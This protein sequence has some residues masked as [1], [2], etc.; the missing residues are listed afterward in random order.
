MSN[1]HAQSEP[2]WRRL[3]EERPQQIIEA[4]LEVFGEHGLSD[5]RLEDIAKRAGVS[6]GTIYLYFP[7]KEELFREV[8]RAHVVARIERAEHEVEA[9]PGSADEQLERFLRSWWTFLQLPT[10]GTIYRLVIGELHRFPDLAE[11]Y[12]KE[13]VQRALNL[14]AGFVRRGVDAGEFR[15]VDAFTT[16]RIMSSMFISHALWCS[17]REVFR[18]ITPGTA[19]QIIEDLID[20]VRSALRPI[21]GPKTRAR[22]VKHST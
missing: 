11:F 20:F 1:A 8:V 17:K 16:A 13:V 22:T 10:S 15:D 12:A 2:K 21:T 9:R 4:A 14:L 18:H 5:A 6:K 7:N 3:P 19:E